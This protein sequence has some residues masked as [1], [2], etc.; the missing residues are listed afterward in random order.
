M[1][2]TANTDQFAAWNGDSGHRWVASADRRDQVLTPV[3]DALFAAALPTPRSRV[4]DIGCG[5]GATTLRAAALVGESG[6]AT[7]IDLSG[8]MLDVARARADSGGG[9]AHVTFIH[10]DAQTHRLEPDV[11]DVAIS[12]FGTMFFSDAQVAFANIAR[13]L[14]PGG[15]MCLATWQPLHAND[16]LTIPGAALLRHT[17]FPDTNPDEPGMFAQS[18]PTTVTETLTAAGFTEIDVASAEITFNLG[19]APDDALE[20]L[21]DSGPGRVMLDTIPQGPTRDAALADVRRALADHHFDEGVQL[22]GAIWLITA[23]ATEETAP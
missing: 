12:R 7:G 17:S 9:R 16:W 14:R 6:H 3:A 18:D 13:A 5:C 1:T 11:F 2:T 10:G 15:R 19:T 20:H 21:A 4:L 8:P 23:T 22:N